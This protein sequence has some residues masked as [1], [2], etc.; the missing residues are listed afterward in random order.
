[1]SI[2]Q[3]IS[4]S[5]G[6]VH[7]TG[8]GI[9]SGQTDFQAFNGAIGNVVGTVQVC[10]IFVCENADFTGSGTW[11]GTMTWSNTAGTEGAGTF[12]GTLN[13]T[14]QQTNQTGPVPISGDWTAAF[15][16]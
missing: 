11:T 15:E 12:E 10:A 6:V 9:W 7:I 14:G 2:D 5:Y 8:N 13:F 4:T 16:T 3:S 1:M